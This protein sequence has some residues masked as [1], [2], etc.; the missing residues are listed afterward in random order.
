MK[1]FLAIA[2]IATS[3][4]ACNGG[5][6]KTETPVADTTAPVVVDTTVHVADTNTT[7][8]VAVDSTKK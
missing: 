2:L 3:F 1:K 5:E 6:T 8:P 4:V 7:A